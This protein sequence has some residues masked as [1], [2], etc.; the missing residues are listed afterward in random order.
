MAQ[1]R[2][3]TDSGVAWSRI[4]WLIFL[5]GVGFAALL[6]TKSVLDFS[7]TGPRIKEEILNSYFGY[8]IYAVTRL[9]L[10]AAALAT[11]AASVG[12]FVYY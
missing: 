10:W 6:T 5:V 7:H 4:F 11:F 8:A 9:A 3:S 1:Q 12:V 2:S